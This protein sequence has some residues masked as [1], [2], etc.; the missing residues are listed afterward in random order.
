MEKDYYRDRPIEVTQV[1]KIK[2]GM[3]VCICIK[4]MQPYAK[5]V[6]D[7]LRGVVTRVLTKHSHPRGLKVEVLQENGINMV[8]RCIYI[9]ENG[10]FLTKDGWKEEKDINK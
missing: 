7:L 4:A 3:E 6:D 8:G 10:L 1:D 9:V 2:V 5:E